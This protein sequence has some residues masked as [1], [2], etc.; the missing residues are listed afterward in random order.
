MTTMTT[1]DAAGVTAHAAL[2]RVRHADVPAP[3]GCRYC[4][5]AERAHGRQFSRAV[6]MHGWVSPTAAQ[7]LARMRARRAATQG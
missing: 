4:G 3:D 5:D 6:G 1:A 2:V 7:R